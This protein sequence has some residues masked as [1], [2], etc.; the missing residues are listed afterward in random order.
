[1]YLI[2]YYSTL[3]FRTKKKTKTKEKRKIKRKKANIWYP[4]VLCRLVRQ[5]EALMGHVISFIYKS[6]RWRQR[7]GESERGVRWRESKI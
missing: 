2:L 6:N 1:M 7:H 4:S 5:V 3:E